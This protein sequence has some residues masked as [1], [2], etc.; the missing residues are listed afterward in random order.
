MF[1]AKAFVPAMVKISGGRVIAIRDQ[2][3]RCSVRRGRGRMFRGVR[4]GTGAVGV[5]MAEL[6]KTGKLMP[7]SRADLGRVGIGVAVR[8]GAAVPDVATPRRS[9]RR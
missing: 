1:M 8:D 6:E 4:Y 2:S 5:L 9:S 3:A 7:G